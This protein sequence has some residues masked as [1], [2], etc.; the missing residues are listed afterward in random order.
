MTLVATVFDWFPALKWLHVKDSVAQFSHTMAAQAHLNVEAHHLEVLNH[1]FRSWD[2]VRFPHPFYASS[3]LILETFEP[4]RIVT[5]VIDQFD[6][7]AESL[8]TPV[9][10]YELIPV[11]LAKFLVTTGVSLYLKMLLV[12]NLMVRA[13]WRQ[14]W[15][16][17]NC[18]FLI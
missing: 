1:N 10:G 6:V 5:G 7:A 2:H 8:E 16:I 14:R 11:D 17:H 4:G 3:S 9:P 13:A 15:R 18:R 12:D